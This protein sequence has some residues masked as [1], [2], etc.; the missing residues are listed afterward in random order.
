M[1][2]RGGGTPIDLS[3]AGKKCRIHRDD[4]IQQSLD[5]GTNL[6]EI[7]SSS[8][9]NNWNDDQHQQSS[10]SSPLL[11]VDRYDARTLLDD[12]S[13]Q[14]LSNHRHCFNANSDAITSNFNCVTYSEQQQQQH[15]ED[16]S[17]E[18]Q[19]KARNFIRYGSLAEYSPLKSDIDQYINGQSDDLICNKSDS[20]NETETNLQQLEKEEEIFQLSEDQLEGIPACITLVSSSFTFYYIYIIYIYI[21]ISITYNNGNRNEII[22][23]RRSMLRLRYDTSLSTRIRSYANG[24][25]NIYSMLSSSTSHMFTLY[26]FCVSLL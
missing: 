8:N 20:D 26:S 25:F 2:H 18:E 22:V 4:N 17:E 10:S 3:I 23:G 1:D 21:Y 11:L 5:K 12:I 9:A 19:V 15:D 16:G 6:I 13:L 24:L 7:G 14:K